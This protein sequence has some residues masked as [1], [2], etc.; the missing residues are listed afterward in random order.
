MD[1]RLARG[2]RYARAGQVL[3]L[4]VRPGEVTARVQ[5]SRRQP[6]RVRVATPTIAPEDWLRVEQAMA[7]RAVFLAKLLAGEM[8]RDIEEAFAEAGLS[9]FPSSGNDVSADCSCPDWANPC[10]HIA[11]VYYLLAEAFD[12]DPFLIFRWR[13]RD[14]DE[15]LADLLGRPGGEVGDVAAADRYDLWDVPEV[16]VPPLAEA[17]DGFWE[18]G[19]AVEQSVRRP[20]AAVI[21]DAI[22]RGLE[23]GMIDVAGAPLAEVLALAYPAIATAAEQA[24]L[25]KER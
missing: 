18:A 12:D 2:R 9:L 24:A 11:A 20:R 7:A 1:T 16:A 14:R 5:G 10:K 22:L 3:D 25:R 4:D 15:L 6:Y 17:I 23:P 8:P 19:E 21:P 13:G